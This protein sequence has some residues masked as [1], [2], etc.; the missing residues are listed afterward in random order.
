M[1]RDAWLKVVELKGGS[2]IPCTVSISASVWNQYQRD[3][4]KVVLRYPDIFEDYNQKTDQ[5]WADIKRSCRIQQPF[6]DS[7]GCLWDHAYGGITGQVVEHPLAD[8]GAFEDFTPPDPSRE[9]DMGEVNWDKERER[10]GE[11]RRQNKV[12][13]GSSSHGFLFQRLYYLR[14]FENLMMDFATGDRR[15]LELI[16]M[17]V[18][19]NTQI[20]L[21]YLE[22][23]IDLMGFGDD[24]GMQERLTV[25]P[26]MWRR[27]IKPAYAR[28]FGPCREAGVHVKLHSDGYIADILEDMVQIGVTITNP[29]DLCNGLETI[30]RKLKGKVC[31][32]LDID[33]QT[34][35][36]WGTPEQIERHIRTCVET[37]GSPEG[38]LML[39]CGVY[40]GTPLANIE[41]VIGAMS[42][43]RRM[44]CA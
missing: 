20:V 7:W 27:Y 13:V 35:V 25:S 5:D 15:I 19:F 24:L 40:P 10:I 39:I 18:E 37:L 26:A 32:D 8:W 22:M 17:I 31:I 36:P 42:R 2:E 29:Q 14:G 28:L 34:I 30:R 23:G 33:R 43:C 44:F 11:A 3:L 1:T 12:A 41:A 9:S 38:G 21:R 4:E 16:D 6:K